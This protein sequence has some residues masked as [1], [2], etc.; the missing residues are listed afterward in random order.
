MHVG[1]TVKL[2]P[3]RNKEFKRANRYRRGTVVHVYDN[4]RVRVLWEGLTTET[5]MH[6]A[7]L[8]E[9]ERNT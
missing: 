8:V 7:L 1:A 2:C 6:K 3:E 9:C 5:R 4:E